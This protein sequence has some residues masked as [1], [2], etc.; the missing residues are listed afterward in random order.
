[1]NPKLKPNTIYHIEGDG[2]DEVTTLESLDAVHELLRRG[3]IDNLCGVLSYTTPSGDLEILNFGVG[4]NVV[5]RNTT[6]SVSLTDHDTASMVIEK[7]DDALHVGVDTL[8]TSS[9]GVYGLDLMIGGESLF[10]IDTD[11]TNTK[12]HKQPK[13][14]E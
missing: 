7:I 6:F 5:N 10:T 4:P 1:M 11:A 9:E 12:Y 2:G 13:D 14:G 3:E 8:F